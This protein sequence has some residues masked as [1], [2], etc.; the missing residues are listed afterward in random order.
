MSYTDYP[1]YW[2]HKCGNVVDALNPWAERKPTSEEE[3]DIKKWLTECKKEEELERYRADVVSALTNSFGQL[4]TMEKVNASFQPLSNYFMTDQSRSYPADEIQSFSDKTFDQVLKL[5]RYKSW[6]DYWDG[7]AFW[8]AM[9]GIGQVAI[10][11]AITALSGGWLG[12]IGNALIAEGIGDIT[13]AIQSGLSGTFSWKS[14]GSHKMWSVAMTVCACGL[15]AYLTKGAAAGQMAAMG[16]QGK[17][18]MSLVWAATKVALKKCG[19]AVLSTLTSLGVEKLLDWLKKFIIDNILKYIA[20]I[21]SKIL[22]WLSDQAEDVWTQMKENGLKMGQ[23]IGL[24]NSNVKTESGE[25][26]GFSD[27]LEKIWTLMKK[28]GRTVAEII[29]RI[30]ATVNKASTSD[31]MTLWARRMAGQAASVGSAIGRCFAESN[32]VLKGDGR[33]KLLNENDASGLG[34]LKTSFKYIE[35]A[36]KATKV[37]SWLKNG[38]EIA[39]LLSYGPEYFYKVKNTLSAEVVRLENEVEEEEEIKKESEKVEMIHEF[40]DNEFTENEN[41]EELPALLYSTSSAVESERKTFDEYKEK[42]ARRVEGDITKYMVDSVTRTW[43]QPWLQ[44]KIETLV[45]SAGKATLGFISSKWNGSSDAANANNKEESDKTK[46]AQE[47]EASGKKLDGLLGE[48]GG[49][50]QLDKNGNPIVQPKDFKDLIQ[51]MGQG[52]TAGLLEMQM[53]ADALNLDIEIANFGGEDG[54]SLQIGANGKSNG[55]IQL[56]YTKNE[57]GTN[58]ISL[59]GPDGNPIEFPSTSPDGTP[60]PGNRCLYEAIAGSQNCPVDQLLDNVKSHATNNKLAEY[61]YNEQVDEALPDRRVG[62]AR[63]GKPA[64][65]FFLLD[66]DGNVRNVMA[67]IN[68]ANIKG[69][70]DVSSS[71]AKHL[72]DAIEKNDAGEKTDQLGHVVAHVLGGGGGKL[73]NNTVAMNAGVNLGPY[74]EAELKLAEFISN[75][76]NKNAQVYLN[77]SLNE[78]IEGPVNLKRPI[79]F[80]ITW[81]AIDGDKVTTCKS[82][83]IENKQSYVEMYNNIPGN[84]RFEYNENVPI[85]NYT[86]PTVIVPLVPVV[87]PK[88]IVDGEETWT[89]LEKGAKKKSIAPSTVSAI[90]FPSIEDPTI[91]QAVRSDQLKETKAAPTRAASTK[92]ASTSTKAAS[93]E[94]A[95]TIEGPTTAASTKAKTETSGKTN[96][97]TSVSLPITNRLL[98]ISHLFSSHNIVSGAERD[99]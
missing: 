13:F 77:I 60:L 49:K 68:L 18:G 74:R 3:E 32:G 55:K 65:I 46:K 64:D 5:E 50:V 61:L 95:S 8:V 91:K 88:S 38:T 66:E 93:T 27:I 75:P 63:E 96:T 44:S 6:W 30:E 82:Q 40:P 53:I 41:L 39:G 69:G 14:Y 83:L 59:K 54:E 9:M 2:K 86:G 15:G 76:E 25:K 97:E 71:M 85:A 4:K 29:G 37:V 62:R 58:H 79:N 56:I 17:V 34:V 43:V 48:D 80:R 81:M 78:G 21:I 36:E 31:L 7:R 24:I 10:G 51:N 16:F 23:F 87:A 67:A 57:D 52:R 72:D 12:P 1:A 98:F 90:T 99:R 28:L 11:V 45:V 26:S 89:K 70:S 84:K 19:Q 73:E 35:H 20:M 94:S 22:T 42:V 47:A 33:N 92:S